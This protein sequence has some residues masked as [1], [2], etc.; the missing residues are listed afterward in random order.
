MKTIFFLFMLV[1]ATNLSAQITTDV[2]EHYLRKSRNQKTTGNALAITGGLLLFSD[3][4]ISDGEKSRWGFGSN[5]EKKLMIAGGGMV[6][7]L[8]SIPFFI[9]SRS[10]L[11]KAASISLTL[12]KMMLPQTNS[13][14]MKTQ[15]AVCIKLV[16][17]E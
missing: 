5:F 4:L 15:P 14:A 17:R 13:W 11:K 3:L 16:L 12:Q 1:L 2:R 10:N 7:I 8:T 9:S 6:C